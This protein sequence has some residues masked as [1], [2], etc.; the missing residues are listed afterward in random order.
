MSLAMNAMTS[1]SFVDHIE[2]QA[3]TKAGWLIASLELFRLCEYDSEFLSQL[4][5]FFL[6]GAELSLNSGNLKI[7]EA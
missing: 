3:F 5:E 6:N 7:T 2:A 1:T 4:T